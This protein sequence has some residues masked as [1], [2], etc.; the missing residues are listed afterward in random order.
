M[1]EHFLRLNVCGICEAVDRCLLAS[2]YLFIFL[3]E[4]KLFCNEWYFSMIFFFLFFLYFFIKIF[5]FERSQNKHTFHAHTCWYTTEDWCEE[6][7]C[8][9]RALSLS[10]VRIMA[11]EPD[12]CMC[13]CWLICACVLVSVWLRSVSVFSTTYDVYLK[14]MNWLVKPVAYAIRLQERRNQI[15]LRWVYYYI[16]ICVVCTWFC[17]HYIRIVCQYIVFLRRFC[18]RYASHVSL[19]PDGFLLSYIV[20]TVGFDEVCDGNALCVLAERTRTTMHTDAGR[21]CI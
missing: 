10:L 11:A 12:G 14:S 19:S 6:C 2:V 1:Y 15:D 17:L 5:E 9:Q 3:D 4:W 21:M 18:L 13:V 8:T 7:P 16:F 20:F